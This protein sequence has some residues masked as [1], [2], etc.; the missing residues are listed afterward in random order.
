MQAL[1]LGGMTH[2][3]S[4]RSRGQPAAYHFDVGES[5]GRIDRVRLPGLGHLVI[6]YGGLG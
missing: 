3:F 4:R 1:N 6:V 2:E 5:L